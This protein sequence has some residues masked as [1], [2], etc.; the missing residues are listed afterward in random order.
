MNK[1]MTLLV[2]LVIALS[3]RAESALPADALPGA[4]KAGSGVYS[5][6][7]FKVYEAHLWTANGFQSGR[8]LDS[9]LFLKLTYARSF[10]GKSI[11]ERSDEEIGRLG[12][13]SAEHRA[14]WLERMKGIFPNVAKGDSLAMLYQPGK[15][16]RFFHNDRLLADI[17]DP[18]F[19]QAFV[20]IWLN[21]RTS[22]PSLR[23]ALLTGAR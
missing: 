13:A 19:A 8:F 14:Q 2:G 20:S 10:P 16:A 1:V 3:V 9:P 6:L 23:Q 11:A 4:H 18:E 22:A 7:G 15:G 5:W 21:P 17:Q 12:I